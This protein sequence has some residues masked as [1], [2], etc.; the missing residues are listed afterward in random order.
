MGRP[1]TGSIVA[2]YV[3]LDS[4]DPE[5]YVTHLRQ[6]GLGMPDR[7]YYLRDDDPFPGH[8]KAYEEYISA[9]FERAGIDSADERAAEVMGLETTIAENHWTR[10]EQRYRVNGVVRNIDAWY[11]AFDIGPEDELYLPPEK[12]V[13][14]W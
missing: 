6:S 10:V 7:D 14:I 9:T 5:R 13:S 4:G 2:A 1:G 8:R 3:S 11:E 12:R